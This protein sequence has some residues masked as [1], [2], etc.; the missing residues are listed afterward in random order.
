MVGS[1]LHVAAARATHPDI[2]HAQAIGMISKFNVEPTETDSIA[3][4]CKTHIVVLVLRGTSYSRR[5]DWLLCL[6]LG[7]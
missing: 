2:A 5:I 7:Q 3:N 1:L 6:R 4:S